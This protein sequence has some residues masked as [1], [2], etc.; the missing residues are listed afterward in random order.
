MFIC[1][2]V[3]P[4]VQRMDASCAR[5]TDS[6]I[7]VDYLSNSPILTR[8]HSGAYDRGMDK[9]F[10]IEKAGSA[11]ELA[12]ILNLSKQAVSQWGET[13]P[14]LQVYRLKELRPRWAA[15]WRRI[16]KVSA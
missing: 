15:E 3:A 6:S 2:S 13:L 1:F 9:R 7:S 10:A 16:Q 14:A 5:K 12:R 8:Q 4:T 11:A